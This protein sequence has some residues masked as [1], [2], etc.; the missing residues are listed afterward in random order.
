MIT[1]CDTEKVI[2]VKDIAGE[3]NRFD[4]ADWARF[5]FYDI[6]NYVET[7]VQNQKPAGLS[8]E[9]DYAY[10]VHP[11]FECLPTFDCIMGNE[12]VSGTPSA[13]DADG[14]GV[15]NDAD[16]C[17]NTFNP[18]QDNFDSDARGDACDPCPWSFPDCPCQAPSG[19]DRDGDG[20]LDS[21]DNCPA[22]PNA[23]QDD[24]DSDGLGDACDLCPDRPISST[25][26][27]PVSIARIKRGEV[28]AEE[29]V[30]TE[31]TVTGIL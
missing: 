23:E 3:P 28:P 13:T 31:G 20:I 24:T 29:F 19:P 2:C 10:V 6:V 27:C 22:T 5:G 30:E 11:L 8:P 4:R 17:P 12:Y 14:D 1:L 18:E 15:L 21:S 25:D 26:A 7:I 9:L 16:N